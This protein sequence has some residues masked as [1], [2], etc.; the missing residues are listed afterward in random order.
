MHQESFKLDRTE[1]YVKVIYPLHCFDLLH[2]AMETCN[3][4]NF[5]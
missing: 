2:N 3:T 1:N 5:E 4:N